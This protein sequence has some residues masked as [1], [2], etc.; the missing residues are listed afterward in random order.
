MLGRI[1][2]ALI[3]SVL[4]AASGAAEPVSRLDDLP[5][6]YWDKSTFISG[7]KS[8]R[9]IELDVPADDLDQACTCMYDQNQA[10]LSPVQFRLFFIVMSGGDIPLIAE[11]T[12]DLIDG[13]GM[14][15][16]VAKLQDISAE[17]IAT[18]KVRW[19]QP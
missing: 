5:T 12:R 19:G 15:S 7:C 4:A 10:K 11:A 13:S 14:S 8:G 2:A 18:C 17:V 9:Y 16:Y 6:S 3:F 1:L